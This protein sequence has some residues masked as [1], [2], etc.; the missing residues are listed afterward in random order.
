MAAPLDRPLDAGPGGEGQAPR[1]PSWP[2]GLLA[3]AAGLACCPGRGVHSV[4]ERAESTWATFSCQ[5]SWGPGRR[6][7]AVVFRWL[8]VCRRPCHHIVLLDLGVP[9][10]LGF[11]FLPS[12]VLIWS[13]LELFPKFIIVLRGEE[14]RETSR[15]SRVDQE[16]PI[17]VVDR[18][19][20]KIIC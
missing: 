9:N 3:G 12:R 17:H 18:M 19:P 1:D 10:Q 5:V 20:E 15:P 16:S 13:H 6:G 8:V 7:L 4:G 2:W 11:L 14:Q